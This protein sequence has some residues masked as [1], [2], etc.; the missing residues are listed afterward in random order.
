MTTIDQILRGVEYIEEN[1]N[2]P[3]PPQAVAQI[4]GMSPWHFQRIFRAITGDTLKQYI[5]GRRLTLSA[6]K[7]LGDKDYQIVDASFDAQF[8]SQE[9]FTRA[10]KRMF[11]E[12]PG[13]FRSKNKGL[14]PSR[15]FCINKDFLKHLNQGLT[16]EPKITELEE[17]KLVG[18]GIQFVGVFS[19]KCD[20]EQVIPELW[21]RFIKRLDEIKNRADD[22]TYGV[23]D[24]FPTDSKEESD[25]HL[26]YFACARVDTFSD[27]PKGMRPIV[28]PTSKFACFQHVGNNDQIKDTIKYAYGTWLPNS[29]YKRIDGAELEIYPKTESTECKSGDH[30]NFEYCI[31]LGQ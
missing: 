19:D 3:L 13:R 30:C 1:L 2:A 24:C 27:I 28:V 8:E 17:I 14:V 11:G 22:C 25:E 26:V 12:T 10:F 21:N 29:N 4:A 16:M 18:V 5:R 23:V 31:P 9:A 7:L 6:E 15:K 20:S